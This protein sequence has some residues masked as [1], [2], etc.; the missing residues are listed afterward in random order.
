MIVIQNGKI[1]LRK[2]SVIW[3]KNFGFTRKMDYQI[4]VHKIKKIVQHPRIQVAIYQQ[5]LK[6]SVMDTIHPWVNKDIPGKYPHAES[7][8]ALVNV[9]GIVA[10]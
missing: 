2:M 3:S 10:F 5:V 1:A 9:Y 6:M 7:V 4:G 8:V